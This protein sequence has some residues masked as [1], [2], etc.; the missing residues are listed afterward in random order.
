MLKRFLSGLD[1]WLHYIG[2]TGSKLLLPYEKVIVDAV[3][4]FLPEEKK[5]LV[6]RQLAEKFFVDRSN[7]R[8]SVVRLEKTQPDLRISDSSFD[9][10]LLIVRLTIN[11]KKEVANVI[12]H[13]GLIFSV[14]T[15]QCR[16]FYNDVNVNVVG[17]ETGKPRQSLTYVIDRA[18]HGSDQQ[19]R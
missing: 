5:S 2:G 9:D 10:L 15:R 1:Q 8:I 17:V 19:A 11:G 3:V 18:E 14:E 13:R 12:F 7:R 4:N 16:K 6:L